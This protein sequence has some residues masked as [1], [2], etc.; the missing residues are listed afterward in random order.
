M[1]YHGPTL[2]P[3]EAF[4]IKYH[5]IFLYET[6]LVIVKVKR[7]SVYEPRHWFPL[8]YFE[9]VDVP[10][11][12]GEYRQKPAAPVTVAH[13]SATG[14]MPF[15]F[16]L[17]YGQHAFELG[18]T[19][20]QEK[21]IW[22]ASLRS[23]IESVNKMRAARVEADLPLNDDSIVS[24]INLEDSA[25]FGD[26]ALLASP[27]SPGSTAPTSPIFG[28]M[29]L[30]DEPSPSVE[31]E[32]PTATSGG[33]YPPTS[34]NGTTPRVSNRISRNV[35]TL[36]GRTPAVT[37]AAIDLKLT[38]VY[39]DSL[40]GC[41]AQAAR[42]LAAE[43]ES[44]ARRRT[45]SGSGGKRPS[46]GRSADKRKRM[47]YLEPSPSALGS[48]DD[49]HDEPPP[50]PELP[51]SLDHVRNASAPQPSKPPVTRQRGALGVKSASAIDVP[52]LRQPTKVVSA[53]SG[54]ERPGTTAHGSASVERHGSSGSSS[55][56]S[57][58]GPITPQPAYVDVA[59]VEIAANVESASP[60]LADN[61]LGVFTRRKGPLQR[62]APGST[63]DLTSS[64]EDAT[65]LD[66]GARSSSTSWLPGLKLARRMSRAGSARRSGRST[67]SENLTPPSV[68]VPL[69]AQPLLQ[70][71]PITAPAPSLMATSISEPIPGRPASASLRP[72][73]PHR[74]ATQPLPSSFP[75]TAE[76]AQRPELP[77]KKSLK[78][79]L[80]MTPL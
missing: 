1:L 76:R 31:G 6:H 5:G 77:R 40:L 33:T 3:S 9:V 44:S 15:S 30:T 2:D 48:S 74:A 17:R 36:L 75:V 62:S 66:R 45:M 64:E 38:E 14:L 70:T 24:S 37:Q 34:N 78:A 41:R 49:E 79:F 10:E 63:V 71:A 23:T 29:P 68:P 22:L 55:S 42:E 8:R 19:C 25:P 57:S 28:T 58:G 50:M 11:G 59:G 65:A 69:P 32:S 26:A 73:Q 16:T 46:F 54:E 47:S 7:A 43:A 39:S 80:R 56:A 52:T 13:A 60:T 20:E 4:K 27:S 61:F 12:S 51:A 21:Q 18:A 72:T 67:P 35:S 53:E